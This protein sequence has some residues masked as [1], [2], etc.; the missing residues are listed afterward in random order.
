M[1]ILGGAN[2]VLT[3]T[4]RRSLFTKYCFLRYLPA[5]IPSN[6]AQLPY[7]D[8]TAE[9]SLGQSGLKCYT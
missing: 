3:H 9:K 4:V 8:F 6:A 2:S 5:C 1:V 7:Q